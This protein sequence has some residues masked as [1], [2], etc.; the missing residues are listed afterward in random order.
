MELRSASASLLFKLP[1]S[2][3][4]GCQ[5]YSSFSKADLAFSDL[6]R[7]VSQ[8]ESVSFVVLASHP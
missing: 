4:G 2:I 6:L 7:L 8:Q 1:L 5:L 3:G